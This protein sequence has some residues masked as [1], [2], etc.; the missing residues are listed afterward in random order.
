VLGYTDPV[1]ART[2]LLLAVTRADSFAPAAAATRTHFPVRL[3]LLL[4]VLPILLLASILITYR[5]QQAD[6]I[7]TGI[8][9]LGLDVSRMTR[10]EAAGAIKRHLSELSRRP[11]Y[12]RYDGE[13]VTVN[14]ASIGLVIDDEEIT[15]LA[16]RAW[17]VGR[18]PQLRSWMR[19]QS[20]LIRHGFDLAVPSRIDRD[21]AAALLARVA[22]DVERVTVNASLSVERAGDRFEIHTSPAFTG[23]NL[24]VNATIDRL[25]QA[26]AGTLPQGL[27]L[28]LV[29]APPSISDGDLAPAISAIETLLGTPLEFR[30]GPRSWR[31]MPNQAFEMLEIKGMAEGTLPVKA[32]LSEEKLALFVRS[33]AREADSPAQNPSFAVENNALV[34]LPG[35]PGKLADEQATLELAKERALAAGATRT[36]DIVFTPDQP[37]LSV[38]DLE[39]AREEA[40]A[41][42]DRPILLEAPT[43]SATLLSRWELKRPELAQM[44][45]LPDTQRVPRDYATMPPASRPRLEVQLDSGRVA[46]YLAREVAP[47]VSEDPLDAQIQ[48]VTTHVEIPNPAYT[49]VP[50]DAQRRESAEPGLAATGATGDG[51]PIIAVPPTLREARYTVGL[52]NARDG[53]GPDYLA[54][55]APMQI[56][57]RSPADA[58]ERRVTVRLARRPPT[59]TDLDLA[60]AR[61]LANQL[62]GEPIMLRWKDRTWTVTREE[63]VAMLRYHTGSDG[64][65]TAYLTR[66]GLLAKAQA[67]ASE[68]ERHPEAPRKPNGEVL[69]LDIPATAAAIWAMATT[70]PA[71]RAAEVVWTEDDL[72]IEANADA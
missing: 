21:R 65:L 14:L 54:T 39:P 68:A 16:E 62:I 49:A 1:A 5:Q 27:D 37:W 40:E 44:L 69:P 32:E 28:M 30:D 61:D 18:E 6:R 58:P 25:T 64:K 48:L 52:R 22:F 55:F 13:A 60:P 36:V 70:A 67:I 35:R 26:M 42:L 9:V 10:E 11:F 12:L 24:D 51:R 63:L 50:Q 66:D 46:N 53:Q 47:W 20:E 45:A 57:L 23:R 7:Y 38:S 33:V 4:A 29:E 2:R 41:L 71:N 56:A 72:P 59:I 31:L 3:L 34:I 43:I 19:S 8:R 15:Q 17:S